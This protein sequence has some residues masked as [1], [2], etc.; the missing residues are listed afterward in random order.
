MTVRGHLGGMIWDQHAESMDPPVPFMQN[1]S[2]NEFF[3][4]DRKIQLQPSS[5]TV[6]KNFI[7]T[8][9]VDGNAAESDSE[10]SDEWK[11]LYCQVLMF[12]T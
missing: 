6:M 5:M 12:V 3:K 1:G 7:E 2:F 4:G 8:Y 9:T 11:Y 10:G